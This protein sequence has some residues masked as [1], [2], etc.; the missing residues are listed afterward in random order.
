MVT[1][2]RV[3]NGEEEVKSKKTGTC[4]PASFQV[5]TRAWMLI[6]VLRGTPNQT[7]LVQGST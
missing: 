4:V 1:Q 3:P 2:K 6:D 7:V 5:D